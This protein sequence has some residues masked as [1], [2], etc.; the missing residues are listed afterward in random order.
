MKKI[1][2][3]MRQRL[4][5]ADFKI[6]FVS[7][8]RLP[9]LRQDLDRIVAQ[10][11][12]DRKFYDDIVGRYGLHWQFDPAV[13]FPESQSI[14]ITAAPHPKT[15]VEFRFAGTKYYAVIPPTYLYDTDQ[16]IADLI[17]PILKEHGYH[18]SSVLLPAKL[19][20]VRSGLAKYGRNNITYIDGWG[21]YYRL[22]AFVSDMPCSR[23][24]WRDP[25]ALELCTVCKACIS[26]CP[27]HAIRS[28][29]FLVDAGRCLTYFNEGREDFPG[30]I[31]AGWHN[32][33]IG[34]MICQ[35]VC[36]ANKEH[37]AWIMPGGDFSEEETKMILDGVL[38]DRLPVTTAEKLRKVGMLEEYGLLRR[39]LRVL[40]GR[41]THN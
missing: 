23:D 37:T 30:W 33:L 38:R 36:P 35:D 24:D 12:L 11:E 21:S 28:D 41:N 16:E 10:G 40:L 31:E 17:S 9:E 14:I 29:R 19:L 34:C 2:E 13:D 3:Q 8:E 6:A 20:A 32:C 5:K 18:M 25:V 1:H 15:S 4:A 22:R 27:T 26:M 39:N 7:T